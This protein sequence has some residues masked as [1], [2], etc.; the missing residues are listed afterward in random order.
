MRAKARS[1][2]GL[3][4]ARTI[5]SSAPASIARSTPVS[6]ATRRTPRAPVPST[7]PGMG[8]EPDSRGRGSRRSGIERIFARG[9]D[10][11]LSELLLEEISYGIARGRSIPREPG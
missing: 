8:S 7:R 9:A 11:L 3:S 2:A 5:A 6:S 1:T 10:G 4:A